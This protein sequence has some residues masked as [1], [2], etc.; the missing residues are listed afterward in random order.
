METRQRTDVHIRW[1]IRRDLQD[2][3]RIERQGFATPWTFDDFQNHMNLRNCICMVATFE[4]QVVGFLVYELLYNRFHIVNMAV[5]PQSLRRGIG[6]QMVDLLKEKMRRRMRHRITL[7]VGEN[8]L[9][10]Q[11]FFKRLGFRAESVLKGHWGD[12]AIDVYGF[13]LD[14]DELVAKD[15]VLVEDL[16]E[17][18]HYLFTCRYGDRFKGEFLGLRS[19]GRGNPLGIRIR[20]NQKAIG[21]L[22]ASEILTI[23]R[24]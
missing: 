18:K 20:I 14:D 9:E 7:H 13:S 24:T 11:L 2:V 3:L 10:A 4:G 17:G 15:L 23:V 22:P 19:L 12:G 21:Y 1:M 5:D 8:N 6:T 16:M